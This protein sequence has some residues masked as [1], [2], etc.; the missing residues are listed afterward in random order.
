MSNVKI[1]YTA[2]YAIE[3]INHDAN[4]TACLK[5]NLFDLKYLV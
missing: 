3:K 1:F 4:Q 2:Y 5:Q